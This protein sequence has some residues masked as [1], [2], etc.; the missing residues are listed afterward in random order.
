LIGR[1][2]ADIQKN[3]DKSAVILL[4]S[5][6]QKSPD[7]SE[8]RYF[9]GT[10]LLRNGDGTGAAV[11]LQKALD[12]KYAADLAVPPLAEAL[13]ISG[14]PR[15]VVERFA[16]LQLT[17][18]KAAATLK[19][20]LASA[21]AAIGDRVNSSSSIDVALDLDPANT[22]AQLL[23]ARR[24][25]SNGEIDAALNQL[26][27]IIAA[28]PKRSDALLFK[29]DLLWQAKS[30]LTA[31][32]KVYQALLAAEP[33]YLPA[34]SA[35][36]RLLLQQG[37]AAGFRTQFASLKSAWP[38][39][40]T[41]KYFEV[42]LALLDRDL[43]RARATLQ[44]LLTVAASDPAVLHLAGFLEL[45]S[46]ALKLAETHLVKALQLSPD[47]TSV[48]RLLAEVQLRSGQAAKVM[49]TL[50]PLL[51]LPIPD[52]EVLSLAAEAL[53][54]AGELAKAESYY[55][56]AAQAKPDDP[57][58]RTA[59]A[60]TQISRGNLEA[61][62]A[63]LQTLTQ[64]DK[65]A[66][67]DL[68]LVTARLQQND[69]S[70][71]LV[72]ID[73]LQTKGADK[74]LPHVLRGR[75]LVAQKDLNG[76][77]ASLEKALALD[78]VNFAAVQDLASIDL[79]E[80]KP[81][82]ARKRYENL[83]AKDP[84]NHLALLAVAELRQ[85]AGDK[86]EQIEAL[87]LEVVKLNPTEPVPRVV[88]IDHRMRLHQVKAA[89]SAAQEGLAAIPDNPLILDALGRAHLAAGDVRQALGAF[90]KVATLRPNDPAPQL[91]LAEAH[92]VNNDQTAALQSLRR[93]LA[94]RPDLVQAQRGLVKVALLG[95]RVDE[96]LQVARTVQKQRPKESIGYQIEGEIHLGQGNLDRA[97]AAF[98]AVMDRE[99][100][101]V[102]AT[103]LHALYA[104]AGR[105]AEAAR[106]A[107]NWLQ[108]KPRDAAFLFYLGTA[109]VAR[110]EFPAAEARYRQ[111]LEL[112]PAN[113][114]TLNNLAWLLVKLGKPGAVEMAEQ[115]NVLLRDHAPFLDTLASAFAGEKKWPKAIETQRRAIALAPQA[116][117]LRLSLAQYLA[118]SGDRNAARAELE[119][120][121]AL[122]AAFEG[123]AAVAAL[124]KTL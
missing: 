24:A 47:L 52:A 108:G 65:T 16:D 14:Q 69:L 63:Q 5:A 49:V 93:A 15:K 81:L 86:P 71:A 96:A 111:V 18:K 27:A 109:A 88:L 41:T 60:L 66:Y 51:D 38:S 79:A 48:R 32:L 50:Q 19:S 87:L 106:L 72:A 97:Q 85:S 121:A 42:Q 13:L 25:A 26:D 4:K 20:M 77:R 61:G 118:A 28:K 98:K 110:N 46:G 29:G 78:P 113:A 114:A 34:H 105:F 82:D 2:R 68:A 7:S 83:L 119:H 120:L 90:N 112:Q 3:D 123:Q 8:A 58:A 76:A 54:Q 92:L 62:F 44:S 40:P 99:P 55:I 80:Q 84:K 37:D 107:E 104:G 122:G 95:K 117:S 45:Q 1:A 94:M 30:D 11:E 39:H 53:L 57:K 9:L 31:A 101:T 6:L 75:V 89:I 17:D 10:T 103:R 116:H 74:P 43:P 23:S 22:V 102:A 73:R 100:S 21:Y 115:A 91:R 124:L 70:G 56:R 67:A 36:L 64:T 33:R 59:L 35:T 12:L